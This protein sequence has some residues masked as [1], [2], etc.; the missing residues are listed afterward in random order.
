MAKRIVVVASAS[1]AN[2]QRVRALVRWT[3]A[4]LP[5]GVLVVSSGDASTHNASEEGIRLDAE[6][7]PSGPLSL[8]DALARAAKLFAA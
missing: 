6:E 8:A 5:A 3:R 7:I 4:L 1:G 2:H